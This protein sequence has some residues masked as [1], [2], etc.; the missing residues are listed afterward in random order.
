MEKPLNERLD[1]SIACVRT[2][3]HICEGAST[4]Y[5]EVDTGFLDI[6]QTLME[7]CKTYIAKAEEQS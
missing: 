1:I 6:V 5:I 3:K 2:L 7:D 4:K